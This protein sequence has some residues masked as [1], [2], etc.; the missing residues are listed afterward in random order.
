MMR[1]LNELKAQ[2]LLIRTGSD[3]SGFWEIPGD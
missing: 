3:K 1:D 2:G